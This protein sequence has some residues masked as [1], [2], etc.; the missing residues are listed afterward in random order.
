MSI[1]R[2]MKATAYGFMYLYGNGIRVKSVETNL[3]TIDFEVA[4]IFGTT[5][6]AS[7]DDINP[8]DA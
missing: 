5:Y 7:V 2:T 1:P 3:V 6:Y 8:I 4:T